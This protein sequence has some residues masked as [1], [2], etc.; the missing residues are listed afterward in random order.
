MEASDMTSIL[1][2]GRNY[3]D[4]TITL[5]IEGQRYEYWLA[6][7][8]CDTIEFLCRRVS[9]GKALALAKRHARRWERLQ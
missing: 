4:S 2:L 5:S 7:Q 1:Y 3:T 6:P 9:M 8:V